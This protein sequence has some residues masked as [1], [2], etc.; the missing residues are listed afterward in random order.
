MARVWTTL[1]LLAASGC[2]EEHAAA[3]EPR[4]VAAAP[5]LAPRREAAP[6]PA[7][8][9]PAAAAPAAA[10]PAAAPGPVVTI[11]AAGDLVLNPHALRA[12][13]DDGEGG[14]ARLLAGYAQALGEGDLAFLNLEQ[15]LVGDLVPLDPGWPRQDTSRPRRSPVLGATPPLADALSAAGVDVVSVAN[16]HAY[17]QGYEG[18]ART[19]GELSRAGVGAVGG[20]PDADAAYAPLVVERAGVRI[21]F[22]AWSEFFNQRPSGAPVAL[23]ARFDDARVAASLAR[24]RERADLVVAS[25][26]WSRDFAPGA[27]P[28]ERR[29]ARR[30]VALGADVI[31]GHGPHVL[32]E[33]ERLPS[34]R[35][36]AL[37]AYSLG[38]VASGMGRT[39]VTGQRPRGFIHPANVTPEARDGA[40]L[41]VR[42]RVEGGR[43]TLAPPTA[44]PLWTDNNWLA[45]QRG[46]V[47]HRV[48]VLRLADAAAD[49]RRERLPRV[50][51]ALGEAV[52]LE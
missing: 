50:A 4:A 29:L 39:Y 51:R 14:Y 8:A 19:L 31:L 21:A 45:A 20:G 30:L 41:R 26:H 18:L 42:A 6:P 33:V 2:V 48:R 36:D 5:A 25:V 27:A 24:A 37:V 3:S 38:N 17:D 52:S 10:A 15:P 49:V 9:A 7:V 23:A 11:A 13:L 46:H 35:G 43:I 40:V 12:V 47:P 28:S 34:P 32:H 44:V 22:V 16:N 1:V